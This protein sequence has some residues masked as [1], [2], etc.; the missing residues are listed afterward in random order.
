[1]NKTLKKKVII[2]V[3]G[4][5]IYGIAMWLYLF[6]FA[7]VGI[8]DEYI[9]TAADPATFMTAEQLATSTTFARTRHLIF[10][11]SMPFEWMAIFFF[12]FGGMSAHIEEVVKIRISLRWLQVTVYY[13]M[14]AL[15][16]FFAMLPFRFISYQLARFY[17]TS[18]MSFPHWLRNRGID[19]TVDFILM[20]VIIGVMLFLIRKF[21]KKW[22]LATWIA[23]IPFAF[24][25]MLI[26]PILID[27][28]YSDFQPIQNPDLEARILAMAE[29]AGVSADRVFEVVM[30]DRTN[31]I[32][33]YVTGVGPTARIVLWDT[34]IDQLNENEI[35]FL[36][37]H[38]IAHYVYRDVY[39]GIIVA[40][41]FAFGGL[42]VVFKVVDK[43][44]EESLKRIPV[45]ILTVS[46]LLFAVSP[47]TNA[48]SRRIEVRADEFALEMTQ[49]PEAGIGL[50]QTL[51][52]TALNE[53]NPPG[54]VQVFRSTHPS[55]SRRIIA[56]I[57]E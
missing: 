47:V 33:G 23:F 34:A 24:F 17:G 3:I 26:Q 11:L 6:H 15:F 18:V 36:M 32:N 13:L 25:F 43:I 30:S 41:V 7:S 54:L 4:Y 39:R 12:I 21:K 46:M 40:I 42:Y 56:L 55:I 29:G 48:I 35:M 53:V 31:T 45:A 57:E 19:F 37:A 20:I 10:F 22:W 14:F 16:T 1:M 51:S 38:E 2:V 27:P 49:D 50:F 28:L 44:E 8:P 9:G 5:I 52:T